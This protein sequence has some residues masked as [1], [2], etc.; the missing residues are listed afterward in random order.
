MHLILDSE[1]QI[2]AILVG[3]PDDP[4]WRDINN[5]DAAAEHCHRVY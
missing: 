5:L 1:G 3:Q 2:I 4:E